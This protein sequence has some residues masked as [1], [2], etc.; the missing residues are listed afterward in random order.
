L[1][2]ELQQTFG[3]D[4]RFVLVSIADGE[5]AAQVE[6]FIARNGLNW[7]HG[8]ADFHVFDPVKCYKIRELPNVSVMG[9]DERRHR[10]PVTF[11]IGPDGRIVGH[12]LVGDQLEAV[13]KAIENTK[14]FPPALNADQMR[15][16]RRGAGAAAGARL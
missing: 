6:R 13:R 8:F 16:H 1:L 7:T 10:I 5:H 9:R 3:D 14:L 2:R 12:D 4:P 15:R 11:S